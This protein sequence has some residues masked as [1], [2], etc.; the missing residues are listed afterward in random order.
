MSP[1][2]RG[3]RYASIAFPCCLVVFVML[4]LLHP[5]PTGQM[6]AIDLADGQKI[7]LKV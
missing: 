1:A 3:I 5:T 7:E 6:S 4:V 2:L